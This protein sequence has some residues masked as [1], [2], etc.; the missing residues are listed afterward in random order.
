MDR[1][2]KRDNR[3]AFAASL[4]DEAIKRGGRSSIDDDDIGIG[5]DHRL[6]L[7]H[8]LRNI[9]VRILDRERLQK[10]VLLQITRHIIHGLRRLGHPGGSEINIGPGH[11]VRWF[12]RLG[13]TFRHRLGGRG[14]GK[15]RKTHYRP[16]MTL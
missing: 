7:L 4:A 5:V 10:A 12:V 9:A 1:A 8:L 14:A 16:Q 2:V 15:K 13:N 3:D 6:D 11:G